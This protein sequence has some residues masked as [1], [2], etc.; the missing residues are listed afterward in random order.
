M[1]SMCTSHVVSLQLAVCLAALLLG[2]RAQVMV[3]LLSYDGNHD[4]W[5]TVVS[6]DVMHHIQDLK[7][8]VFVMS[9]QVKGRTLLPLPAK[10]D[11]VVE[12]VKQE[13]Q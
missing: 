7:G 1:C 9:G 11:T 3:P 10:S 4:R 12:A 2:L 5:P 6:S 13:E 8:N